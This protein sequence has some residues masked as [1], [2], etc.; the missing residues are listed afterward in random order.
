MPWMPKPGLDASWAYAFNVAVAKHLVF[1]RD[2]IFTFGP[3]AS[4]YTTL[5][6]PETDMT[7]LIGSTVVAIGFCTTAY[8]LVSERRR[9]L[10]IVLP[11]I[12]VLSNFRDPIFMVLP[13]LVM[14]CAWRRTPAA[15]IYIGAAAVGLLPLIKGSLTAIAAAGILM[16]CAI[17][18]IQ[19][20]RRVAFLVVL[21][22]L[23]LMLVTWLLCSQPLGALPTYIKMQGPVIAGYT[24][25][26][27]SDG[28][29]WP[30]WTYVATCTA[31][32]LSFAASF[33]WRPKLQDIIALAGLALFSAVA[34]KAG[35]VR[36][37]VHPLI[38]AAALLLL[39]FC[40]AGTTAW[41]TG[42]LAIFI[43]IA[44]W[45][46]IEAST[47][48]PNST[49][50]NLSTR[51]T[52]RLNGTFNGIKT[53]IFKPD[54]LLAAFNKANARIEA[55][56]PLAGVTGP[57]DV[58]PSEIS[59]LFANKIEW[60]PRPII[61]SYSAYLPVL[62]ALNAKHLNGSKAPQN[63]FLSVSPLDER[64]AT[65]EDAHSW[66]V[67]LTDYAVKKNLGDR[68]WLTKDGHR[69]MTFGAPVTV[70]TEMNV[71]NPVPVPIDGAVWLSV[72]FRKTPFGKALSA[73]Y[74]LSPVVLEV[75]LS[76]GSVSYPRIV[77][78][79][80]AGGFLLSPYIAKT[81]DFIAAQEGKGRR[82]LS[83]RVLTHSE[84]QW[85]LPVDLTFRQVRIAP[86]LVAT[87]L[88]AHAETR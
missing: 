83:L 17:A 33:R 54:A 35:F 7:M 46:A 71:E 22:P 18:A 56:T 37:D 84:G 15:A 25:A 77:P 53:R 75:R 74:K 38:S 9:I 76:D 85:E 13:M 88:A 26:M 57:S 34:F 23:L 67:L 43:S 21:L 2:V 45:Y 20:R 41:Q 8:A 39:A 31:L 82:V 64:I 32:L 61:Q 44:G 14:L 29:A 42:A 19:G 63:V 70:A 10:L 12:V 68:L 1:G 72:H 5:Y 49:A 52:K 58:Y 27:A 79:M 55:H 50:A 47:T 48:A 60:S 86:S 4:V 16:A 65:M 40:V 36:Q 62:D 87:A 51:V 73:A 80:A 24:D 66:P 30:V 59:I 3:L 11:M 78:E 28:P 6:G 81:D 69:A